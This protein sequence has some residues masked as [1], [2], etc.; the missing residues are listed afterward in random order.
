M[1]PGQHSLK[2]NRFLAKAKIRNNQIVFKGDTGPVEVEELTRKQMRDASN[3]NNKHSQGK[4]TATENKESL[5]PLPRWI[6][7]F[8][9]YDL[10]TMEN[11]KGGFLLDSKQDDPRKLKEKLQIEELKKQR[12]AQVQSLNRGDSNLL[13]DKT[14]NPKCKVCGLVE[15]DL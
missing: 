14:Q 15:L 4:S 11:S 12:L 10:S 13:L 3:N 2:D 5:K 7:K 8:V 6:C 1:E 9:D